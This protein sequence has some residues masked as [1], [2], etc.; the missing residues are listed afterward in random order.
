M[1]ANKTI[2]AVIDRFISR[3]PRPVILATANEDSLS[4]SSSNDGFTLLSFAKKKPAQKNS[5]AGFTI[6]SLMPVVT[7]LGA[8]FIASTS[9]FVR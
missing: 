3:P 2:M 5:V 8:Q 7:T 6:R 4:I 9:D 1:L